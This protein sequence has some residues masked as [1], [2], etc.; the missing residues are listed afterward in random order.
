MTD[1]SAA[2]ERE[3]KAERA[4]DRAEENAWR[5]GLLQEFTTE[6]SRADGAESIARV[7][8]ERV[9]AAAGASGSTFRLLE[10]DA[11]VVTDEIGAPAIRR[12]AGRIRV[13]DPFPASDAVR[14]K[15]PVWLSSAEEIRARFPDAATATDELGVQAGVALPLIAHGN[16]L[17]VLSLVFAEPRV[18][19]LDERAFL[20]SVAEQCAQALERAQLLDAERAQRRSAQRVR[21]RLARLQAVTAALGRVST[22]S[23]VAQVLVSQAKE[24]L[25]ASSSVAYV[26]DG[27]KARLLFAAAIGGAERARDRIASLPLDAPLPGRRRAG[28]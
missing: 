15:E 21:D 1:M 10:G 2:R 22:V 11:L 8:V 6:L 28:W 7:V 3:E 24:A 5:L 27:A 17:G 16:V 20:V 9:R 23:E 13:T 4:R 25:A 12:R 19:D 26:L 18:F 14:R